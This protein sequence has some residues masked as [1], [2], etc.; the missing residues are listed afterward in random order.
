MYY[1]TRDQWELT[2]NYHGF[3]VANL[4]ALP[5]RQQRSYAR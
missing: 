5:P 3:C 2:V 4:Y 1:A